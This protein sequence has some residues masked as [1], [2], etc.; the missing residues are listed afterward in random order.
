[1]T[2]IIASLL[3]PDSI[4]QKLG[5]SLNNDRY[6]VSFIIIIII[7]IINIINNKNK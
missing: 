6:F 3:L 2:A 1:M 5:A 7:D 4:C